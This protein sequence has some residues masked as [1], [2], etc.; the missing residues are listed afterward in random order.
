MKEHPEDKKMRKE[1]ELFGRNFARQF[2]ERNMNM[3]V[4]TI[5]LYADDDA[6]AL[7]EHLREIFWGGQWNTDDEQ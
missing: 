5:G 3:I 4:D 1:G 2:V 7:F 6:Q